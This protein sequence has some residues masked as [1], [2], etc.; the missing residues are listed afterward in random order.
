M[1]YRGIHEL[2]YQ[3]GPLSILQNMDRTAMYRNIYMFLYEN[4]HVRDL[5]M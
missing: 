1:E 5:L 3:Y 2:C 4:L